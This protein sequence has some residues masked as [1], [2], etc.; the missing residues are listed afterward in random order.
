MKYES[1]SKDEIRE[2]IDYFFNFFKDRVQFIKQHCLDG[3]QGR[4]EGIVLCCCCIDA[5][6]ASRY[7]GWGV[8]RR[9]TEFIEKYSGLEQ[10]YDKISLP[11]LKENLESETDEDWENL[12]NFLEKDLGVMTRKYGNTSYNVDIPCP[13]LEKK[14][15]TKFG[16]VYFTKIKDKIL[17]FRYVDIFWKRYR[18]AS[19]HQ[20]MHEGEPHNIAKKEEPYYFG[21][22]TSS[23]S[24]K[25][26]RFGIPIVFMLKTLENCIENWRTEC[27]ENNLSPLYFKGAKAD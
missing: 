3:I 26:I 21:C 20:L 16:I 22:S 8:Y 12:V 9:F 13:K 6:A 1:K 15:R 7:R 10:T 27:I 24:K 11:L 23:T 25:E 19:V 4:I 2:D 5:L 17:K 14:I 18:C